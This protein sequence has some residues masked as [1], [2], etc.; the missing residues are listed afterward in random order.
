MIR[1]SGTPDPQAYG[2]K[3]LT[4]PAAK[5]ANDNAKT[6]KNMYDIM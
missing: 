5:A 4:K 6:M 1:T 3:I 2:A